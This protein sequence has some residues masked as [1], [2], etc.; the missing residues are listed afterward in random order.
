MMFNLYNYYIVLLGVFIINF[1]LNYRESVAESKARDNGLQNLWNFYVVNREHSRDTMYTFL[2]RLN[3]VYDYLVCYFVFHTN[4]GSS[5]Y[6]VGWVYL[7][8]FYDHTFG[9]LLY[10][11][12]FWCVITSNIC[13]LNISLLVKIDFFRDLL[14]QTIGKKAF[15]DIMGDNPGSANVWKWFEKT[16]GYV[17]GGLT[18]KIG[19]DAADFVKVE[20]IADAFDKRADAHNIPRLDPHQWLD[21]HTGNP[22][23]KTPVVA[24]PKAKVDAL[25]RDVRDSANLYNDFKDLKNF[26]K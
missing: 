23:V 15:T 6:L 19:I 11:L 9:T 3:L 26:K 8:I 14:R 1:V 22:V 12:V 13:V 18:L 2:C 17:V 7:F 5:L 21:L 25:L 4:F 16:V 10:G 20:R 24:D